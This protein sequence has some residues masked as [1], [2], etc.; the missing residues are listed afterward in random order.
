MCGFAGSRLKLPRTVILP[1]NIE[2]RLERDIDLSRT[3]VRLWMLLPV[4]RRAKSE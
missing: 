1:Q 2:E 3:K 4:G